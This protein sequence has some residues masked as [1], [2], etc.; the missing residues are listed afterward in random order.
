MMIDNEINPV[1]IVMYGTIA[2]VIFDLYLIFIQP[3]IFKTPFTGFALAGRWVGYFPKGKF[4]HESVAKAAPVPHEKILGWLV[5]YA[6]G[7]AFGSILL[8]VWNGWLQAPTFLPAMIVGIT[9]VLA[10]F[11]IM[12]PAFGMGFFA[13]KTPD[14]KAARIRSVISHTVFGLCLYATGL[15]IACF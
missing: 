8:H 4:A 5:H 1:V 15:L 3:R 7:I 12:Q 11:C 2:T 6:T 9:S 13:S 14:P 10:P